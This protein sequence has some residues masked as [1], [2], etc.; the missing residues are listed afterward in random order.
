MRR[1]GIR[2]LRRHR[3]G[4]ESIYQVTVKAVEVDGIWTSMKHQSILT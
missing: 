4:V 3:Y 1:K 2:R